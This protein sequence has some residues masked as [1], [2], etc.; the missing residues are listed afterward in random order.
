MKLSTILGKKQ[1][2][3]SSLILI[4]GVAVYLNWQ[5]AD[6]DNSFSVNGT[7]D[8]VETSSVK[9]YGDAKLVDTK[10][11]IESDS[12]D[13][14]TQARLSRTKSRSEATASIEKLLDSSNLSTSDKQEATKQA[15]ELTKL[16]ETEV[17]AENLIKAKG[18]EDCVVYI[19]DKSANVIVKTEGLKATQAAQIKDIIVTETSTKAENIRI[20]EVE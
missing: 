7:I 3:L 20:V 1:I 10:T 8:T 13:Y 15:V 12:N 14:F 5:F 9:N 4:L 16:S 19:E 11:S 17:K 2:I 6:V 18:F